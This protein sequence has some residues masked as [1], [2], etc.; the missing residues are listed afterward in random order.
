M[1]QIN[2]VFDN[3]SSLYAA[4]IPLVK[5]G[6]LFIRTQHSYELGTE[7]SLVVNLMNED[8]LYHIDAK[9]VWITPVEAQ[10][11]RFPGVGVQFINDRGSDLRSKIEIYLAEMLKSQQATDTV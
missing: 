4:Y 7:L 5:D 2:C 1:Q 11:S 9:V 8:E 6:G 3:L 10:A